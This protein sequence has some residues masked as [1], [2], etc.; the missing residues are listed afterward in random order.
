MFTLLAFGVV[1]M[2]LPYMLFARGLREIG[3]AEAGLIGLIEPIL[4][5]IW[6]VLAV[7][8]WPAVPTL[9]RRVFPAWRRCLPLLAGEITSAASRQRARLKG[10]G[11]SVLPSIDGS[12]VVN[13]YETIG[14]VVRLDD[15]ERDGEGERDEGG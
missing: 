7:G 9:D 2:A 10:A 13:S 11:S 6:V 8:E 3:T 12:S 4:N 15:S 14:M 5:P 1:Q